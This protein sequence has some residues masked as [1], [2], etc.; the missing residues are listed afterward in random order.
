LSK[1]LASFA[2]G[3][4]CAFAVLPLSGCL[5]TAQVQELKP[6]NARAAYAEAE[7]MFIGVLN[8]TDLLAARGA[9]SQARL[10]ELLPV[11]VKV[12]NGLDE[13]F[14]LLQAGDSLAALARID[15]SKLD[16]DRLALALSMASEVIAP[17]PAAPT[18]W[19]PNA[20]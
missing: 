20:L 12:A 4:L 2:V 9:I 8:A 19:S 18:A 17:T 15:A 16:L 11:Y 6:R 14:K 13:A 10:A 5:N 1:L 7:I 3:A